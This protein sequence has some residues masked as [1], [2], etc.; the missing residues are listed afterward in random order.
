M[1]ESAYNWTISGLDEF[2]SQKDGSKGH[3]ACKW[4]KSP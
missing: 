4:A 1:K 2:Q 3:W